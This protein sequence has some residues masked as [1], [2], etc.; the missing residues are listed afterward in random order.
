[1]SNNKCEILSD[2]NVIEIKKFLEEN[3]QSFTN[4]QNLN[5]K[6]SDDIIWVDFSKFESNIS[7]DDILTKFSDQIM[8]IISYTYNLDENSNIIVPKNKKFYILKVNKK[9]DEN[10]RFEWLNEEDL[11]RILKVLINDSYFIKKIESRINSTINRVLALEYTLLNDFF[12]KWYKDILILIIREE[13]I[14]NSHIHITDKNLYWIIKKYYRDHFDE[15]NEILFANIWNNLTKEINTT[16]LNNILD[17]F[18][19]RYDLDLNNEYFLW[20]KIW[21]SL[22]QNYFLPLINSGNISS[23]DDI[24]NIFF[25]K[26]FYEYKNELDK[27]FW[28]KKIKADASIV[29]TLIY[30]NMYS[31]KK[32]WLLYTLSENFITFLWTNYWS[33]YEHRVN[34]Y[35][36]EKLLNNYNWC[37]EIWENNKPI[38]K[39]PVMWL[40]KSD[41]N[42]WANFITK[43]KN[44]VIDLENK[45]LTDKSFWYSLKL[46]NWEK[47]TEFE[48]NKREIITNFQNIFILKSNK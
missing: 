45:Y 17:S 11:D 46:E 18:I 19:K 7:F 5:N 14:E 1:M 37:K 6:Y 21:E 24:F 16:A 12:S 27:I 8:E 33:D 38:L 39:M 3:L 34:R 22:F 32:N 9:D 23:S 47:I 41:L 10:R 43:Y 42:F 35:N 29:H 26:W 25:E 4:K 20:K 48:K 36:F 13:I 31:K 2:N 40:M 15:I 28:S 30:K 44:M